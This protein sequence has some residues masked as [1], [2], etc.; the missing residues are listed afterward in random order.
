MEV[1]RWSELSYITQSIVILIEMSWA[2][3]PNNDWL[4]YI[5]LECCTRVSQSGNFIMSFLTSAVC[6]DEDDA[7]YI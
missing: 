6:G 5:S 1:E 2:S 3:F 7:K 4:L